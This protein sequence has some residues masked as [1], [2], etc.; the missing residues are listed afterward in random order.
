MP[1]CRMWFPTGLQSACPNRP[2]APESL[3][4]LTTR[5]RHAIAQ[6]VVTY[7]AAL[8]V[9]GKRQQNQQTLLL[10]RAMQRHAIVPDVGLQHPQPYISYERCG[11]MPSR[12]M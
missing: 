12:G 10:L 9:C 11:A 5:R 1:S 4:S 2:A 7:S 8:S 6:D 3:T